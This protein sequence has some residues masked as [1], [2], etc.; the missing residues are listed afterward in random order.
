VDDHATP[1]P[2]GRRLIDP[3]ERRLFLRAALIGLAVAAFGVTF[4]VTAVAAGMSPWL[5]TF[6][7]VVVFAGASQFAFVAVAQVTDPFSGALSG[8]L[9]NL[10]LVAFGYALAPRLPGGPVSG[11]VLDGYLTTDESAAV[12]FDGP[13]AGTRRRL[14][15]AGWNVWGF[16]VASSALGAFGGDL[17]GD[18]ETLGLDVAFP[19]AFLALLAPAFR[20]AVDRRVALLA[21]LLALVATLLLPAGLAVFLAGL[22]V[23]PFIGSRSMAVASQPS[24]ERPAEG[25]S[26]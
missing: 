13:V 15:V 26:R 22:A 2:D 10:R 23:L 4:G 19:A 6:S 9:L 18:I 21:A 3:S 20:R 16:W 1:P 25:G 8:I 5:A 14:R 17:L 11:R 24:D 12:A 7:S